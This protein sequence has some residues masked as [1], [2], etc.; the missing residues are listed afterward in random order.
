MDAALI[1]AAI[2]ARAGGIPALDFVAAVK[3]MAPAASVPAALVAWLN[4]APPSAML[5]PVNGF[6]SDDERAD[7]DARR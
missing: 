3:A 1:L 5:P 4:G 6:A 7:F 2:R